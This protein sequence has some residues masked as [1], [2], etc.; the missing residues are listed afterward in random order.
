MLEYSVFGFTYI[1]AVVG[2]GGYKVD[3]REREKCQ[4]WRRRV[5]LVLFIV[6]MNRIFWQ[7]HAEEKQI[8]KHGEQ[9]RWTGISKQCCGLCH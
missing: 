8:P 7:H 5:G 4:C 3:L 6:E 1:F 9:D 2:V